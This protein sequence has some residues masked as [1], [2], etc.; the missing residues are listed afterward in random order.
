MW[1]PKQGY[2]V[3]GE[4]GRYPDGRNLP[5]VAAAQTSEVSLMWLLAILRLVCVLAGDSGV[6]GENFGSLWL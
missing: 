6:L 4:R 5:D 3:T 2:G 1:E